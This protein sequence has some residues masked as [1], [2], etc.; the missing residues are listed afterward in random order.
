[1]SQ[2]NRK[3]PECGLWMRTCYVNQQDT[4][5]SGKRVTVHKKV[6]WVCLLCNIFVNVNEEEE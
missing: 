6:G 4:S 3:C 1:M 2:S 5:K